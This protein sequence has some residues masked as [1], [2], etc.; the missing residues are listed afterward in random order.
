MQRHRKLRKRKIT[1][2]SIGQ[3]LYGFIKQATAPTV[4][5]EQVSRKDR[6]TLGNA[7]TDAPLMQKGKILANV[8]LGRVTGINPFKDE[9]QAPQTINPAGMLNRWTGLGLGMLVYSMLPIK[10]LPLKGKI[11][12]IGKRTL[13]GGMIGGIFD[14]NEPKIKQNSNSTKHILAPEYNT[15]PQQQSGITYQ[16]TSRIMYTNGSYSDSISGGLED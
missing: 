2:E 1:K 16:P 12:S 5:L 10:Q 8:V 14:A 3:K 15:S 7:W 11:G 9:Y 13:T 6:E 4:F